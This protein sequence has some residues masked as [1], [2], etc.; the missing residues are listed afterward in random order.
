[1]VGT[2]M[3]VSVGVFLHQHTSRSHEGGVSHDEERLGSV[4]HLDHWG[5]QE[6]LFE[7]DE[8]IVLVLSPVKIYPLL[9]RLW[10]GQVSTEKFGMNFR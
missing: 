7:L 6:S 4:R 1:M 9:V 5:G 10:S 8:G 3:E 2:G